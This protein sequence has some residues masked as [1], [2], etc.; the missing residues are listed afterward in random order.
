MSVTDE[1][2]QGHEPSGPESPSPLSASDCWDLTRRIATSEH[3]SKSE[4]LPKFLLHI[5][6]R[7]LRGLTEEI[8]EQQL[9]VQVFNRPPDY[10]P[11]D[12]N[13]VRNYA[14]QLRKRL[15]LYFA[16]E[17]AHESIRIKIPRG[18]YVPV[19]ERVESR[20]LPA[21]P[22]STVDAAKAMPQT[23]EQSD[24]SDNPLPE[25]PVG[26]PASSAR[27]RG[28]KMF[29]LGAGFGAFFFCLFSLWLNH[30]HSPVSNSPSA[31]HSLWSEIFGE[32]RETFIV[33]ADSGLGILQNLTERQTSLADYISGKY[34]SDI[35]VRSID[36]SNLDD[37]RTQRYTSIAD[38]NI[39]AKLSRLPEVVPDRSVIR[40][41][42]DLRLEDL[43]EGNAILLGAIHTDPW[44]DLLQKQLNFQFVCE[45]HINH[46]SIVNSHPANDENPVYE[47]ESQ[48]PSHTTYGVVAFIPNLSQSGKILLIEGL[49]MA[50]TQAAADTLLDEAKMRPIL[51]RATLPNRTVIPFELL[52]ETTSV[53]AGALPSRIIAARFGHEP[54]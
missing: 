30:R 1:I 10:N 35:N 23:T 3:F 24:I 37:L 52:I 21:V 54:R 38:V 9:G 15:D 16:G 50:A 41:A 43:Q 32:D 13:I 22:A 6:D 14:G 20:S 25:A 17:G 12:D 40:F 53:D 44:V 19:F 45:S 29:L 36:S 34:L 39:I 28:W 42:R 8:T 4:L 47:N 7:E 49:N 11:G 33:P 5:C 18:G 48:K 2:S 46:C 26:A 27:A 51:Q 31:T